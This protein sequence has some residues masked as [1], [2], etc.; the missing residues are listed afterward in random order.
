MQVQPVAT[1][2][3]RLDPASAQFDMAAF[4]AHHQAAASNG[5]PV[6]PSGVIVRLPPPP[7]PDWSNYHIG[8]LAGEPALLE[9]VED[10]FAA[11]RF[12]ER[13][14]ANEKKRLRDEAYAQMPYDPMR[15]ARRVP[16][17]DSAS[18]HYYS[19]CRD[20]WECYE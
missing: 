15:F 9:R 14:E 11:R 1:A 8:K 18:Q 10:E 12:R 6:R 19:L 13:E 17:T 2:D 16:A 7:Q 20:E 3:A 5:E 4:M